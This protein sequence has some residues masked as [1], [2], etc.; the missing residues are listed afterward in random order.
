M[1]AKFLE[2]DLKEYSDDD[3]KDLT[4]DLYTHTTVVLK[5]QK[6]TPEEQLKICQ[7]IGDVQPTWIPGRTEGISV[8][9]GVVRVTGKKDEKGH[10]GIF[11]HK[12]VLEWHVNKAS[13][14]ERKPI[15]TIFGVEGTKGS[16]TS[17][18]NMID[19]WEDLPEHVKE[20]L[21][22]IKI[23][24][25]YKKDSYTDSPFHKE[26][27]NYDNEIPLVRTNEMG[28]TG[29]FIPFWQTFH[30]V[31]KSEEYFEHWKNYLKEHC[32][33]DKYIYHHDWEDGDIIFNEQWLSQHKRWPFEGMDERV[34]HRVAF[35]PRNVFTDTDY[36][37]ELYGT[38]PN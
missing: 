4:R 31:G 12:R 32:I 30:F 35:D 23:I 26:H 36:G 19:A 27:M 9:Q 34:L 28:K 25:G 10:R 38:L 16:R 18:M 11:G 17:F 22:D 14:P 1:K 6:L 3:L 24:C 20:E 13:N 8:I 37:R 7:R 5:N 33:Q 15:I 21:S 29:L 2:G